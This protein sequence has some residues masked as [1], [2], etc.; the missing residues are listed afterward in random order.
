MLL[1]MQLI[2]N[3]SSITSLFVKLKKRK[4]IKSFF[5][6]LSTSFKKIRLRITIDLELHW[7]RQTCLFM[8]LIS[9]SSKI[10][11]YFGSKEK[12]ISLDFLD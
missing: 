2:Q 5:T 9:F 4:Q 1:N 12:K 6:G 7:T 8:I 11:V 10:T 3:L